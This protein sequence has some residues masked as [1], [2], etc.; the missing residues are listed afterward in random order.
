MASFGFQDGRFLAFSGET[1]K[2]EGE[3]YSTLGGFFRQ[4][5]LIYIAAEERDIIR[6]RI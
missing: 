1:R 5:E 4:Y 6:L 3:S 2:E